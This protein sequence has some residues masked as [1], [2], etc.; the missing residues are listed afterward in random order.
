MN[1]GF[2]REPLVHFLLLGAA[3]F[4]ITGLRG[5]GPA[6]GSRRIEVGP[7]RVE[8]LA[9]LFGRTWQR[10]P[11]RQE[12]EGL[13]DDFVKEEVYYREALAMGLAEDDTIV[14]RRL[15]QKLEFLTD[16]VGTVPP[17]EEELEAFLAEHADAYRIPPQTALD[18]IYFSVDRRGGR[19][20]ADARALLAR[21][22]AGRV[23]DRD[24]ELGDPLLLSVPETPL[25]PAEIARLFGE[26]FAQAVPTL[27]AG[28]W[29]G[30]VESGYGLH[31]VLVRERLE[32]RMPGLDEVRHE[33]E[34]DWLARRREQVAAEFY[35]ELRGRYEV[36]V[37]MPGADAGSGAGAAGDAAG[38]G[39]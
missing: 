25:L 8:Q 33:V 26:R 38:G 18:Q 15:R 6:A 7:E 36:V 3:L 14:R 4:A 16:E 13:I 24:G 9:T 12:L 28:E 5:E 37:R 30:P 10:P 32:G 27:P 17:T 39:R 23:P 31:L 35:R 21:L 1:A 34:R 29:S 22:P 20:A 11:T 2:L 19:A